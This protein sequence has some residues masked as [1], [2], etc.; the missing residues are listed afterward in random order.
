MGNMRG[1][2]GRHRR[3]VW[4]W[5]ALA[6]IGVFAAVG[7][8]GRGAGKSGGALEAAPA[9][10]ITLTFAS[11]E[12]LPVDRAFAALVAKVSGGYLKLHTIYY[13]ARSTSV[14]VRLA[15]ALAE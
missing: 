1:S 3:A 14:D 10:I 8:N 7:C 12:P 4:G 6:L 13:N 5:P 9:G 11:G 2:A 15:A